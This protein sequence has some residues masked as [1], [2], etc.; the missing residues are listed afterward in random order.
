MDKKPDIKIFVSHRI[1]L[2]SETI[3]N[4]LYVNVRCG[5]VFDNRKNVTM[6]GDDTGDNISEKR[7]SF[8]ELTV[9]YWAWKNVKADYYGLCHYR[10]YLSFLESDINC[11]KSIKDAN[12]IFTIE[13]F[14]TQKSISKYNITSEEIYK[15]INQVDIVT[16]PY[17][18][19]KSM[20]DGPFVSV[21]DLCRQ[22]NRDFD[23]SGI[24]VM[25]DI[26]KEYYPQY[27]ECSQK[28]FMGSM[29]KFYNCFVMK[30]AIFQQLC[31]FLFGVLFRLEKELNTEDYNMWKMRMPGF[32]GEHLI[33]IFFLYISSVE[34]KKIAYTQIIYFENA[35]IVRNMLPAFAKNNNVVVFSCSNQFSPYAS[36]FLKSLVNNSNS[37][38]N[39]DIIILERDISLERKKALKK[40]VGVKNNISLRFYNP[41]YLLADTNLYVNSENQSEVAYYRLLVPFIL[42][43]YCCKVVVM[44]CDIILKDDIAKLLS[45]DLK[46][47][48]ISASSDI[49]YH[50]WYDCDENLRNYC[51]NDLKLKNPKNYVNTGVVV[52]DVVLYRQKFT[53]ESIIKIANER[54]YMIQEQDIL[55]F[56]LEDNISELPI[57]WNTYLPVN[58]GIKNLIDNY[59]SLKDKRKYYEAY[60]NSKLLHWAAQP[61]PWDNPAINL[62]EEWWKIARQTDLYELLLF[63]MCNSD[64]KFI[65]KPTIPNRIADKYLPRGTMRREIL[66]KI[67]PR[68]SKQ[69]ELLKKLYHKVTF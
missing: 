66:K 59:A 23:M 26:I 67:M 20:G 21:Y 69:F 3:D 14:L 25:L 61:K 62:A 46:G 22:R 64:R 28:Y 37:L 54:D 1:D 17:E 39:Y 34:N 33:G 36:V 44:D 35:Y 42:K 2:D 16:S 65:F 30:K 56:I 45:V 55:N 8:C 18:S 4:P 58:D 52:V 6:L 60:K 48:I 41:E 24:D 57:E 9:M 31:S 10:R 63:S 15:Y 5:A 7:D 50:A 43:N 53:V 19:V 12:K 38:E 27:Y 51:K 68:G 29:V 40:V 32:M 47:K 49:V 13:K 11:K